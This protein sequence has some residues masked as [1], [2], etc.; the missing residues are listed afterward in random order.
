MV[1]FY[2]SSYISGSKTIFK[3]LKK[4]EPGQLA[5]Y[6]K[7]NNSLIKKS[8]FDY[9]PKTKIRISNDIN[10]HFENLDKIIDKIFSKIIKESKNRTIWVPLSG[11]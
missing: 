8:Y 11:G 5:I 3:N 9:S 7:S 6:N 2:L 1:E 10:K 4:I